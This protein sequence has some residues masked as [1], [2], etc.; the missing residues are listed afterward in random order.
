M[1]NQAK[2]MIAGGSAAGIAAA[3]W[4]LRGSPYSFQNKAVFITGGSR[5]LGLR[6]ARV[7]AKQ[8]ARLTLISRHVDDLRAVQEELTGIGTDTLIF[9]C[10]VRDR[11]HVRETIDRSVKIYGS[12]DVLINNAGVIQVGPV[13]N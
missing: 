3:A 8:G 7:L 12:I 11:D 4:L 5:G 13:E 10:D 1:N 6:M 9:E 2:W